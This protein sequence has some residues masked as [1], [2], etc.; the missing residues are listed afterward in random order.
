MDTAK[1]SA[2]LPESATTPGESITHE[3]RYILLLKVFIHPV[4]AA[5][6]SWGLAGVGS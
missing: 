2:P 1:R 4:R 5:R 3:S 6:E